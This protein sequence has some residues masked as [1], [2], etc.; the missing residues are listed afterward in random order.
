MKSNYKIKVELRSSERHKSTAGQTEPERPCGLS[1][2]SSTERSK[3]WRD[4]LKKNPQIYQAYLEVNKQR[5]KEYRRNLAE[6]Q[7]ENN[8]EKTRL[9]LRRWRKKKREEKEKNPDSKPESK[10]K[11]KPRTSNQ[12]VR[13]YW[14]KKKREYRE[15]ITPQ[16]KRRINEKRREQYKLKRAKKSTPI[17]GKIGTDK[18]FKV[19]TKGYSTEEAI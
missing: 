13:E 15:K 14:R 1:T 7:K 17:Q 6:K 18:E 9:R 8:R 19:A 4:K 16:K 2:G 11:K 3:Q 12:T 10:Q 5:N